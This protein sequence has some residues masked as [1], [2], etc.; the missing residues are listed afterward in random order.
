[1]GGGGEEK[2]PKSVLSFAN[3]TKQEVF[4]IGISHKNYRIVIDERTESWVELG[5]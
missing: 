1:M 2:E 5:V 3:A 4:L